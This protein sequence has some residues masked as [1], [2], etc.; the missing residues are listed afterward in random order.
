MNQKQFNSK[1]ELLGEEI[2][3]KITD[4]NKTLFTFKMRK[5]QLNQNFVK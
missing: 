2:G 1:P 5:Y 3:T 4:Y